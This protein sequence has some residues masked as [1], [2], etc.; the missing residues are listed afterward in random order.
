MDSIILKYRPE[1]F[2]QVYY[3]DAAIHAIKVSL[4]G[5]S[6]PHAYL[7]SGPPGTGKTTLARIIA[8]HLEAEIK[9]ID[10]TGFSADDVRELLQN[11]LYM[12]F[13]SN[14]INKVLIIDEIQGLSKAALQSMLKTVEEPPSHLY[15]VFCTTDLGRIPIALQSRCVNIRLHSFKTLDMINFIKIISD[16]EEYGLSDEIIKTIAHLSDGSPR[17][18]LSILVTAKDSKTGKEV[19][20]NC[21]IVSEYSTLYDLF[22]SIIDQK[23]WS[24]TQKIA[25]SLSDDD[26]TRFYYYFLEALSSKVLNE[27]SR[28]LANRYHFLLEGLVSIPQDLP[29]KAK[30]SIFIGRSSFIS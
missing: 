28:D 27:K 29:Q 30:L 1:S 5:S 3:Q 6:R 11:S 24:S 9:E 13:T 20:D 16:M 12:P 25:E 21:P 4:E 18:A 10:A 23:G 22:R 19:S 17:K 26:V 2:D 7:L 15:F 8:S 14:K